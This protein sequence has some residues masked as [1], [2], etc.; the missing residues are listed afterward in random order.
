M[1]H[2]NLLLVIAFFLLSSCSAN[3]APLNANK[4]TPQPHEVGPYN[5]QGS[6]H[7]T[8]SGTVA[9]SSTQ[10]SLYF[11]N[12][13]G[14]FYAVN[15]QTGELRWCLDLNSPKTATTPSSLIIG[16]PTVVDGVV[17]VCASD[18]GEAGYLYTF[19]ASDGSLRWR[20]QTDCW[21]VSIPFTDRAIPLVNNGVVYSGLSA[22]RARDGQVQWKFHVNLSREGE[23]ILLALVDGVV[24]ASTEG[25]V[26]A[27]NAQNGAILWRYPSH[28]FLNV[29]GP[30]VISNKML[31]VG[32]QGTVDQPETSALY[33]INTENG[34]LRWVHL[35]GDYV[36]AAL[37]NNVA[38][39]S[40]GGPSLDAFNMSSGTVLWHY[41]FTHL[42]SIS[43]PTLTTGGMLYINAD[44]AYALRSENGRVLWHKP[45]GADQSVYFLPP[46]VVDGVD[47]VVR[48]DGHGNSMLYALNASNGAE[49]WQST[50]LP[51]LSPLTVA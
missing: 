2:R 31:L 45:L 24:Y 12:N 47:Y 9:P 26:Y 8:S 38:Y 27:F 4:P 30:L 40:S 43:N 44:G 51:Q 35:M 32:T 28:A 41:K 39:V 36:G 14:N 23:L 10:R 15:A 13:R 7:S 3:T 1:S 49:Y 37:L 21:N 34:S 42:V 5:C 18:G 48:T 17:Y 6:V 29:G 46:V 50:N 19:N 25:A 20:T 16:T 33:A 11:G 22:V